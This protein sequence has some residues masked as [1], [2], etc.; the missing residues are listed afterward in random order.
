MPLFNRAVEFDEFGFAFWVR[1]STGIDHSEFERD[2]SVVW[3]WA[4]SCQVKHK[5]IT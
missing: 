5:M 4:I 2:V 1:M 3:L